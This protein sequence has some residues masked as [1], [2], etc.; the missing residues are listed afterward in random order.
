MA[1]RN[2]L[3]LTFIVLQCSCGN[4]QGVKVE[5]TSV[6]AEKD[7]D[8]AVQVLYKAKTDD[9]LNATWKKFEYSVLIKDFNALKLLSCDSIDCCGRVFSQ[10]DFYIKCFAGVFDSTLT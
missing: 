5:P 1:Y 10:K 4:R 2:L 6:I 7:S 3:I 9:Q 8:S